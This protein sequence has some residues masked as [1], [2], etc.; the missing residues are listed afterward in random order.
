MTRF[1]LLLLSLLA[2]SSCQ[3][4][5][6]YKDF[7]KFDNYTWGRFEKVRFEIP[8]E[9]PGLTA[10]IILSV[11]HITQYPYKNLPMNVIL[12]TP[13]GEERIIEKDMLL[14]DEN[15]EFKGS[16][17]GDLWDYEETLWSQFYFTETGN[18]IIEIENLIPKMGIPGLD[19]IGIKVVKSKKPEAIN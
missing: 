2:F 1:V 3:K 13:S 14:K 16:V 9:E 8:V 6:V 11:R 4:D 15:D 5:L 18:Y 12:M 7:H 10:D 19:D 17:A